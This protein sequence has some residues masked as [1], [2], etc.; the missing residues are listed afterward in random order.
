MH[1]DSLHRI[2]GHDYW[3]LGV[4]IW[5]HNYFPRA[6]PMTRA[7]HPSACAMLW[8]SLNG[9]VQHGANIDLCESAI[10]HAFEKVGA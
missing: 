10:F 9:L 5:L 2:R 6:A 7:D 4:W 8:G 3:V 1:C